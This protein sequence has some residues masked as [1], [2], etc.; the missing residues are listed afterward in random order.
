M[1]APAT[2]S[3]AEALAATRSMAERGETVSTAVMAATPSVAGT[4]QTSFT[5]RAATT[6][7]AVVKAMT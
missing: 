3:S 7:S 2:I 6:R 1:V 5:E 4:A